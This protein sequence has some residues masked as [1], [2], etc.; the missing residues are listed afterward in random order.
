MTSIT[1]GRTPHARRAEQAVWA[2]ALLAAV[3]LRVV[4]LLSG[5]PYTAYVDEGYALDPA[6]H[7][8]RDG[9][10][11][12]GVYR[13]G[14][15]PMM[16]VAAVTHIAEPVYRGL[17]GRSL[18]E[19]IPPERALYDGFEPFPLLLI[20][21]VLCLFLGMGIVI[22][23]GLLA[24]RMGGPVAGGAAVLLAAVT[25]S[26]VIRSP[27]ATVD[28]YAAFFA[29]ICVYLTEV[30]Q[31]SARPGRVALFV[32]I[33]AGLAVA[34]KY[35]A[36]L[37]FLVFLTATALLPIS[38]LEKARR[39]AIAGL[40]MVTTAALGLHSAILH[41]AEVSRDLAFL[42]RTYG[43]WVAPSFLDQALMRAEWDHDYTH[44]E[45]GTIFVIL[46]L[47][48]LVAAI[49]DR[50][51]RP[52]FAG[53]AV[54]AV[55]LIVFFSREVFQPFRNLLALVPLGCVAVGLL[56]AR[57]RAGLARP[58]WAD[59]MFAA[60]LLGA[61]VA[62]LAVYHRE[63]SV[64]VDSRQLAVDW[65]AAHSGPEDRILI[66]RDHA[67]LNQEL[68]RLGGR[69]VSQSWKETILADA[70]TTR[71]RFLVIGSSLYPNGDR[72]DYEGYSPACGD[73]VE[74]FCV[75]TDPTFTE[76]ERWRGN[77]QRLCIYERR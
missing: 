43:E 19:R 28:P 40:A 18:V 41:R 8:L 2:I 23:V 68:E 38:L 15:L 21:R 63:R 10:W 20:G 31:T 5:R 75:G 54:F 66:A 39:V 11:D 32:G 24:R 52:T 16:I 36:A 64:L 62:P 9:G 61:F 30:S 25:P 73:Y 12:P 76:P 37:V 44:P 14:Q 34:S 1:E 45:L 56:F 7:M 72:F 77:A 29:L 59:A 27:L 69:R 26:L 67:F 35:P 58:L 6:A 13:Y 33:A 55:A 65:L 53:C 60:W 74:R 71:P 50:R 3:L 70:E 57:V 51:T 17:R 42:R 4:P 46:A 22:L 47:A 49:R 48:G